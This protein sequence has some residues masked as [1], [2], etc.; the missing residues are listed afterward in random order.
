VFVLHL[1]FIREHEFKDLLYDLGFAGTAERGETDLASVDSF[2]GGVFF[3][4]SVECFLT[5]FSYDDAEDCKAETGV[6]GG[7][8]AGSV[9]LETALRFFYN[10]LVA[11]CAGGAD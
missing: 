1:H 5:A 7:S 3:D 2:G 6:D 4:D 8:V 11:D 10:S 9:G